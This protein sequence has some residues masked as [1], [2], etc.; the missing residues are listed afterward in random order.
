MPRKAQVSTEYLVIMAVVLVI[1]L[2]V[3]YLV[4]GFS[5]F[6][7]ASLLTQSQQ[8]W[9]TQTPIAI[10]AAKTYYDG[11]NSHLTLQLTNQGVNQIVLISIAAQNVNSGYTTLNIININGLATIFPG[12]T[13]TLDDSGSGGSVA[14]SSTGTTVHYTITFIY[15]QGAISTI[16]EIGAIPLALTCS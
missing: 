12:Q 9:A 11:S 5:S 3:V 6:G 15:N 8:Y 2:V 14:C 1:A 4:G 10:T 16:K 7:G 13:M